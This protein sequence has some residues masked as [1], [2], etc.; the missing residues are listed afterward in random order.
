MSRS[1]ADPDELTL[2]NREFTL[3]FP[4]ERA[5]RQPV[6]TVYG[7]GHRFR[8]DTVPRLGRLALEAVEEYGGEP[9]EFAA[10]VGLTPELAGAVH[11]RMRE[12]LLREPVEDFR[13]D[14]EDG[15]GSRPDAEEDGHVAEAAVRVAEGMHAGT[16]PPFIGIR[17]KPLNEELRRRSDR[18]LEIFLRTLVERAGT[19]PSGL[20]VTL[21][22]VTLPAQVA[23]AAR[24]LD[25]LEERLRLEHGAVALEIMVELPQA[26]IGPGG[27]CPLAEL[28]AAGNG[29]VRGAHFGTYD[30]TAGLGITAAWQRMGHPVCDFAKQ[31]M[32]VTLAGTG[33]WL[34]DGAT[35]IMPV[36]LHRVPEG[37]SLSPRQMA[38]NRAGVHRAWAL[39]YADVRHSLETGFYQGWDLHPAQLPTRYGAVF[40]FFLEGLE[41]AG[42]RLRNFLAKAAQATLV[43]NVFD[44]AATG[45][46]LLN[47]FLRAINSGAVGQDEVGR[48]AGLTTED[49]RGR[50]FARILASR[51]DGSE[52]G[53]GKN[54]NA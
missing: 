12:K 53:K 42:E 51:R 39:H 16:L 52:E 18:T 22:K 34:S 25:Q 33:V 3:R 17:V 4:G 23:H 44:D 20:V 15:Y 54:P 8:A 35:G 7:G 30:Y 11:R 32:Q 28:V 38:E 10:A 5:A 43:G 26:I 45:Q 14:F 37:G 50:S 41:A 49:L 13:I 21:P 40:A 1:G 9:E 27:H 29:R 24:L 31:V 36:P 6:H 19:A 2:A 47:Y 46:G 48:M